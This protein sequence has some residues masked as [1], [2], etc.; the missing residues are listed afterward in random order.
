MFARWRRKSATASMAPLEEIVEVGM[1]TDVGCHRD[2]NEDAV[3]IVRA[4]SGKYGP[5][6]VLLVVADGMGGRQAGEVASQAAVEV[7]EHAYREERGTP[8]EA[9]LRAF[10]RA[11]QNIIGL[12]LRSHALTGMG[13]TCTALALVDGRAWSVHVGDSRLYLLRGD[14][15][16]QLSEDHTE[17]MELVRRGAMTL[18]E[19][20]RHQDRNVLS[21]AM[22][23]RPD[24]QFNVWP[25]PL[26]A[27]PG[28]RFLL[29]SDGLHELVPASELL[30]VARNAN[31]HAACRNLVRM[32]R[33]RGGYDNITVAIAAIPGGDAPAAMKATRQYEVRQ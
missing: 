25:N 6:G 11:N 21:R 24:V 7:I 32:A 2:L 30:D 26:I 17:C 9:L 12:A 4:G 23:T 10:E 28:D 3:R 22:G 5:R 1:A 13:T 19:A 20:R 29:C 18:E 8:G 15:I 27:R 33:D 31:P 16:Y 14:G